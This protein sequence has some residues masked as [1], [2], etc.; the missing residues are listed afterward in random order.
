[1]KCKG[2]GIPPVCVSG[3]GGGG[4]ETLL[5][6]FISISIIY[7]HFRTIRPVVTEN[8]SGQNLGEFRHAP[9]PRPPGNPLSSPVW[10]LKPSC[11]TSNPYLSY[12]K[13]QY[14][15]F[16]GYWK[17]IWTR[18]RRRSIL[19]G[20]LCLKLLY[21]SQIM[22]TLIKRRVLLKAAPDQVYTVCLDGRIRTILTYYTI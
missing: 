8:S 9:P 6:N 20:R 17:L 7:P 12:P 4:F 13:F 3:G 10:I 16:S 18:R 2:W 11:K 19:I 22:C 21:D 5:L 15:P 1:M 14:N